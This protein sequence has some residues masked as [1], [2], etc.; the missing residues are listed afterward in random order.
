MSV[1]AKTLGR[2]AAFV[3]TGS[4]KRPGSDER[5]VKSFFPGSD[6]GFVTAGTGP[7]YNNLRK[8]HY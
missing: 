6:C 3:Q 8:V 1:V 4:A 2:D 7:Y 5:H